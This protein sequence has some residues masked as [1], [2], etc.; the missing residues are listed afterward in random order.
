MLSFSLYA[1]PAPPAIG[2][3]RGVVTTSDHNPAAVYVRAA[4]TS[5]LPA[6]VA[7]ATADPSGNF[8]ITDCSQ[9]S[10]SSA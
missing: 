1:Q 5:P 4:R 9:V 10:T 3:I 8:Q 7:A 6:V 2:T